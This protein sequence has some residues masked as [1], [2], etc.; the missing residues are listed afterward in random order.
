MTL[1][2]VR[3]KLHKVFGGNVEKWLWLS[4]A[5]AESGMVGG[6]KHPSRCCRRIVAGWDFG[7]EATVYSARFNYWKYPCLLQCV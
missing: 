3:D 4:A 5:A 6:S 1:S 2:A 7:Y